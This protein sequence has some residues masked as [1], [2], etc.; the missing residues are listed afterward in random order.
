MYKA[1]ELNDK[2]FNST[3]QEQP[4]VL[5]EF[6]APW[7]GHCK[8]QTPIIDKFSQEVNNKITIAKVNIEENPEITA[9]YYISS[10][11]SILIFKNGKVAEQKIGLHKKEELEKLISKYI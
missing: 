4:A 10:I 2:N 7:C 3:I 9:K 5:V 11:P 1:I 8:I 6:Y